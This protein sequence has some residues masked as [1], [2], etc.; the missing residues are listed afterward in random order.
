MM[1]PKPKP[2]DDGP[3]VSNSPANQNSKLAISPILSPAFSRSA[4][5][6]AFPALTTAATTAIPPSTQIL[7]Q[8][9]QNPT[10]LRAPSP[11]MR[12]HSP[13]PTAESSGPAQF[14]MLPGDDDDDDDMPRSH[15]TASSSAATSHHRGAPTPSSMPSSAANKPKTQ[16]AQSYVGIVSGPARLPVSTSVSNAPRS[17]INLMNKDFNMKPQVSIAQSY[18][19]VVTPTTRTA[20][21]ATS[22]STTKPLPQIRLQSSMDIKPQTRIAQS[23]VGVVSAP[24]SRTTPTPIASEQRLS[25]SA[26]TIEDTGYKR[27][28]EPML[29]SG[30]RRTLESSSM[31][32]TDSL[33]YPYENN[34]QSA[35]DSALYPYENL[36]HSS[37]PSKTSSGEHFDSSDFGKPLHSDIEGNTQSLSSS[38]LDIVSGDSATQE[39]R[40]YTKEPSVRQS[41]TSHLFTDEKPVGPRSINV[42]MTATSESDHPGL[43]TSQSQKS[44]QFATELTKEYKV[45]TKKPVSKSKLSSSSF[46]SDTQP[47]KPILHV[48]APQLPSRSRDT[49]DDTDAASSSIRQSTAAATLAAQFENQP[50]KSLANRAWAKP[51]VFA[52]LVPTQKEQTSV[53]QKPVPQIQ[54][55]SSRVPQEQVQSFTTGRQPAPQTVSFNSVATTQEP[56]RHLRG[57]GQSNPSKVHKLNWTPSINSQNSDS[58]KNSLDELHLY[59]MPDMNLPPKLPPRNGNP[60]HHTSRSMASTKSESALRGSPAPRSSQNMQ[61]PGSAFGPPMHGSGLDKRTMSH[62]SLTAAHLS[63]MRSIANPSPTPSVTQVSTRRNVE[64]TFGTIERTSETSRQLPQA[65]VAYNQQMMRRHRSASDGSHIGAI[66][67]NL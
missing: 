31:P 39:R 23:Y 9:T 3:L 55:S 43:K 64:T 59:T 52:Q 10:T 27:S 40:V 18:V 50:K 62:Q 13:T 15:S 65:Q 48:S 35:T 38:D 30:Y 32:V 37:V 19:G 49:S 66:E 33:T 41:R 58:S 67:T 61:R 20:T 2:F 47:S 6:P 53:S 34:S 56:S 28:A 12:S 25:T 1:F 42:T 17:Q 11:T 22:S 45:N 7:I 51:T 16:I 63:S 29:E 26:R 54:V 24:S 36:R 60:K 5:P 4:A 44:V 8:R 21:I 46:N 57:N 14:V